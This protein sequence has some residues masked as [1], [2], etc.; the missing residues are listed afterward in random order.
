MTPALITFT[1]ADDHTDIDDLVRFVRAAPGPVEMAVLFS[2][3]RA[4]SSRYPSM[5]RIHDLREAGLPLAAHLC[6]AWAA[7]VVE[8]GSSPVDDILIGFSRVQINTALPVVPA[9]IRAWADRVSDKA[10]HPIEPILQCRGAFPED[11]SVSWLYD[12]SG[13]RGTVP[14]AWPRLPSSGSVRIGFAGGLGPDNVADALAAMPDTSGAWI[15]METKIRNESDLFDLDLCRDVC[16]IAWGVS[17]E[18]SGA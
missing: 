7:S 16:R 1:G 5:T 2:D 6:G 4:G 15:D 14:D 8:T 9:A 12:C 10:G 11:D 18:M 3:K 13:G 17:P